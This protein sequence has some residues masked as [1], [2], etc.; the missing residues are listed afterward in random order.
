MPQLQSIDLDF[1][2]TFD[3]EVNFLCQ[4][5]I[6]KFSTKMSKYFEFTAVLFFHLEKRTVN[7]MARQFVL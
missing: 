6:L 1:L 4:E 2:V 7:L 5:I 3:N